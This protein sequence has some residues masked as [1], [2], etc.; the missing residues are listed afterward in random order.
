METILN[1]LLNEL[2][3]S[4]GS[5]GTSFTSSP[6]INGLNGSSGSSGSSGA[7]GNDGNPGT[8]GI[9]GSSGTSG[10]NGLNG[11]TGVTGVTG[12]SGSSGSSG[13]NGLNGNNGLSGTA[14]TSG[15]D[16]N[17]GSSGSSGT[18]STSVS[19]TEQYFNPNSF[20]A[21]PNIA[22]N[23]TAISNTKAFR[24]CQLKYGKIDV[25]PG[26]YFFSNDVRV[27]SNLKVNGSG[28]DTTVLSVL[29]NS[30]DVE[31]RGRNGEWFSLFNTNTAPS[32]R[33]GDVTGLS[34]GDSNNVEISNLTI[35]GNY[36]KQKTD[37][38]G[39][40]YTT[41]QS[42]FLEGY[43][44]KVRNVKMIGNA[45]GLG[46][47]ECF[48]TRL[49][50]GPNTPNNSKGGEITGCEVT[51][52]GYC[53]YTHNGGGGYEISC[54]TVSGHKDKKAYGV[55]IKNN[56]IH[57][58]NVID[59]KQHSSLNGICCSAAE[60]PVITDNVVQRFDGNGFYVD[61]WESD[62]MIIKNNNFINVWRGMFF[63]FYGD[64][65][66]PV[67]LGVNNAIIDNNNIVLQSITPT[68]TKVPAP[69]AGI[70]F[71]SPTILNKAVLNN[72]LVTKN[73]IQG[74]NAI[75]GNVAPEPYFSRGIY[76]IQAGSKQFLKTRIFRNIID[77]P[78][79]KVGS[80]FYPESSCLSLYYF[81]SSD[82]LSSD[83]NCYV[84]ETSNG[85]LLKMMVCKSDYTLS[86]WL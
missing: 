41:V 17:N 30:S 75:L 12:N 68:D 67:S 60:N 26:E 4:S 45:R 59:G 69:F 32:T 18:S 49:T 33:I 79:I 61:S 66:N 80:N 20:G 46:G 50:F 38:N 29:P 7:S 25:S 47:G 48:Q 23:D 72:L 62:G 13:V 15:K 56:I 43:N 37:A 63:N 84:N 16:G 35:N 73:N 55:K 34:Y 70:L 53:N 78:D 54:L 21:K 1:Q 11:V 81:G 10:I 44:N 9:N 5:S 39:K 36:N 86:K 19:V 58:M 2:K 31:A 76:L 74:Y 85:K 28:I 24:D 83:V 6:S 64:V 42:I 51:E 52:I 77:T 27:N 3:G 65:F 57:K 8:M 40:Y 22:T 71:N 14:G 82:I